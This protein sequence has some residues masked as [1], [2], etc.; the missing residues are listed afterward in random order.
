MT[1]QEKGDFWK[2]LWTSTIYFLCGRDVIP[3]LA[4]LHVA[5]LGDILGRQPRVSPLQDKQWEPSERWKRWLLSLV[6]SYVVMSAYK[7]LTLGLTLWQSRLSSCSRHSASHFSLVVRVPA[8]PTPVQLAF[9]KAAEDSSNMLA[10][11]THVEIWREF[12]A[13]SFSLA[14]ACP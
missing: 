2:V 14:Q 10:Y 5:S 1:E 6:F 12:L 4:W 7:K 11:A 8:V 3:V 13:P 9:K